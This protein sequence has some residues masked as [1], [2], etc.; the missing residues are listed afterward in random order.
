MFWPCRQG[1]QSHF[2]FSLGLV[3]T[4]SKSKSNNSKSTPAATFS[5]QQFLKAKQITIPPP[6]PLSTIERDRRLAEIEMLKALVDGDTASSQLWDLW[7][8]ERGA[9]AL[10]LLQQGDQLMEDQS[11]WQESKQI[12]VALIEDNYG[13]YFVETVNRLATLYYLQGQME[14]S[15]TLC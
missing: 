14:W 3:G 5:L 13:I 4:T 12:L 9:K 6:P 7:Y 8:S 2:S 10:A 15:Y 11:S 1:P